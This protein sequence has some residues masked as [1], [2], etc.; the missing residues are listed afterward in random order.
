MTQ[1][2]WCGL[3]LRHHWSMFTWFRLPAPGSLNKRNNPLQNIKLAMSRCTVG[4]TPEDVYSSIEHKFLSDFSWL[5]TKFARRKGQP[6]ACH[7]C[8]SD[9]LASK[10][11]H[12]THSSISSFFSI[13]TVPLYESSLFRFPFWDPLFESHFIADLADCGARA[14]HSRYHNHLETSWLS[15]FDVIRR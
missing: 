10:H 12:Q 9:L 1:Q 3:V 2:G 7:P 5:C 14:C 13:A 11:T 8:T 4:I 6:L 15:N